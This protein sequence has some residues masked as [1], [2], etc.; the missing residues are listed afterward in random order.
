MMFVRSVCQRRL[1]CCRSFSSFP[2]AGAAG[3]SS[4]SVG[5]PWYPS[6]V[7]SERKQ[8]INS[9]VVDANVGETPR[10]PPK[11]YLNEEHGMWQVVYERVQRLA[12]Q[13]ACAEYVWALTHGAS[14]DPTLIPDV[15]T[16]SE[17]LQRMTGWRIAPVTGSLSARDFF[18]H[19]EVDQMPCT[20]YIRPHC[21]F[22]FTEDPDCVHEMLGHIPALFIPSWSRCYRAFGET[23]SRLMAEGKNEAMEQLILMYFAVVEKGLVREG[24]KDGPVKAI[25]A[26]V[27]SGT[28]EL[29]YAMENPS[30][31]LPL[32]VDLVM[33]YGST[34]EEGFME[35]FFVG[36]SVDGMAD[37]IVEWMKTL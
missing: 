12:L 27:I 24:G 2:T 11:G 19:L 16:L 29:V 7:A 25:G 1:L 26:S 13:H 8:L 34:D 18:A 37:M 9:V 10:I 32:E 20:M 36:E 6:P 30:T 3:T 31:H 33:K 21:K 28:N 4:G 23:A 5:L 14:Y 22:A 17:R 35:H 15:Q